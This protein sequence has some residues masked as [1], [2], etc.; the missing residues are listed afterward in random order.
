M[1]ERSRHHRKMKCH[2]GKTTPRNI[3][4]VSV[5]EHRAW[6]ILFK[7]RTPENIAA[8]INAVWLDPD[9]EFICIN[10]KDFYED[11]RQLEFHL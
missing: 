11:R 9:Y 3:S 5:K 1:P 4:N 8:Y 6:H 2:G 7:N 10:R